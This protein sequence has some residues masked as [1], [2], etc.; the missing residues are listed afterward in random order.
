MVEGSEEIKTAT[1]GFNKSLNKKLNTFG[2][3][4]RRNELTI[5]RSNVINVNKSGHKP[6]DIKEETLVK[7][8]F[9]TPSS[10]SD[11]VSDVRQKY[12]Q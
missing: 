2:K 7:K 8:Y 9:K 6:F 4:V 10:R 12:A 11:I 5:T 1:S 3:L